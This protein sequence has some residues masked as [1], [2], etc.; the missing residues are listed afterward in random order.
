VFGHIGNLG[1]FVALRCTWSLRRK[2]EK[3]EIRID[4]VVNLG[5]PRCITDLIDRGK[6]KRATGSLQIRSGSISVTRLFSRSDHCKSK[7]HT[8][9]Q[10]WQIRS[11]LAI[12][13]HHARAPV[14]S[15]LL[16]AL[17]AGSSCGLYQLV[18]TLG[19]PI[20]SHRS[21]GRSLLL[22]IPRRASALWRPARPRLFASLAPVS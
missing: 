9:K 16:G 8:K 3:K 6:K 4:W 10:R 20:I 2:P 13:F 21:P 15:A 11:I 5:K 17:I 19:R 14:P 1:F 18:S 7:T 22:A 12:N